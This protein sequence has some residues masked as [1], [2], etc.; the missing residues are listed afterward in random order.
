LERLAHVAPDE[1]AKTRNNLD[2][3]V[4]KLSP[5][6]RHRV[7]DLAEVRNR[8]LMNVSK[9]WQAKK[10]IQELA[11]HDYFQRVYT[12]VGDED[13]WADLEPWKTGY[14]PDDYADELPAEIEA[15]ETGVDWVDHFAKQLAEEGWLHNH[16][17]MWLACYVVHARRVKWQAGAAWFLRHLVDGDPASNNLSWQWVASTFAAKPYFMNRGNVVKFSGERFPRHQKTDPL[18]APYDLL[19]ADLF[20]DGPSDA[21]VPGRDLR[22]VRQP[23]L[24]NDPMPRNAVSWVHED[25]LNPEHPALRGG[26]P[27]IFV[28]TPQ[29]TT[30]LKPIGFVYE[31]LLQMPSVSIVRADDVAE[32]VRRFADGRPVVTG[33]TPSSTRATIARGLDASVAVPEPLVDLEGEMI[34]L[35]RFSRY[36][37]S[38]EKRVS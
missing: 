10:L 32:A 6:I 36:W 25:M 14:G 5:Y 3:A 23:R 34:D 11:W 27:G 30:S 31:C 16:A 12:A 38:V 4:T 35:K 26:R 8:A 28:F 15:G 24:P 20:G 1:Y 13:V 33:A 9:P 37:R 21:P 29:T 19:A 17:R 2:G 7:L 18:D 22:R